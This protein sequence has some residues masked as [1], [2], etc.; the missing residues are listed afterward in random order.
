MSIIRG[1]DKE[2]VVHIHNGMLLSHK[3]EQNNAT[4]SNMDASG[5]SPTKHSQSER[6]R[7]ISYD[8]AYMWKLNYGTDVPSYKTETDSQTQKANMV[9]K[10]EKQGWVGVKL[11]VWDNRYT[12]V[13]M[14]QINN[15]DL[16]YSTGD[17]NQYLMITYN[18]KYEE[19]YTHTHTHMYRTES[20]CYIPETNTTM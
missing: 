8:I 10:G 4:G 16:L 3:K 18:G 20:L 11:G 19:E 5:D 12:L 1:V 9:T 7:Q 13:C 6:E 2:D 15:E 14:K 17:S